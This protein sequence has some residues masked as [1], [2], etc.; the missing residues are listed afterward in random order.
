[1]GMPVG[2]A[3]L[4]TI[5][6]TSWWPYGNGGLLDV[7]LTESVSANG[8]TSSNPIIYIPPSR[9]HFK[10]KGG[11]RLEREDLLESHRQKR[12]VGVGWAQGYVPDSQNT[13]V[14]LG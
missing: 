14:G 3:F 11:S 8:A 13:I 4:S 2:A 1:M 10:H 7:R 6:L 5:L 12:G 9:L